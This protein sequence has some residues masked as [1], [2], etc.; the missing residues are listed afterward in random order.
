M[1]AAPSVLSPNESIPATDNTSPPLN[2]SPEEANRSAPSQGWGWPQPD[3]R[4][5]RSSDDGL[6]PR[7][8]KWH[9]SH[10]G[11]R[12]WLHVSVVRSRGNSSLRM[13]QLSRRYRRAV[14]VSHADARRERN[15]RTACTGRRT[16]SWPREASRCRMATRSDASRPAGFLGRSD[17]RGPDFLV[18]IYGDGFLDNDDKS[19]F[20]SGFSTPADAP[21]VFMLVAHDDNANPVEAAMLYLEYRKRDLSAELHIC[22]KGGHG[23]GIGKNGEPIND[24]PQRCAEWM[25]SLGL[26]DTP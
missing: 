18:F 12:R 10:C 15:V 3:H 8:A 6:P 7:K 22:A 16:S 5:Q 1:L 21:P 25:T 2:Y 26:I 23:F 24:W 13:A 19:K 11:P 4:C 17:P 14:E 20:R 9:V